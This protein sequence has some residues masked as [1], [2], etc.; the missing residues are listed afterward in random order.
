MFLVYTNIELNTTTGIV[1]EILCHENDDV[2]NVCCHFTINITTDLNKVTEAAPDYYRYRLLA[3][4][5][6]RSYDGVYNGGIEVCAVLACT[7]ETMQSCGYRFSN[8]STVSWPTTFESIEIKANF[9]DI[10]SKM[11][12]PNS[13]LSSIRPIYPNSTSWTKVEYASEEIIERTYALKKA[14]DRLITF[15]IW[16]RDFAR[17]FDPNASSKGDSVYVSFVLLLFIAIARNF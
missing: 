5:G 16:G 10:H 13:L 2:S 17:D 15:A 4:T 1:K 3:Y 8:Y 6:V 11:Q 9:T 7:N 14:Q 12:Y